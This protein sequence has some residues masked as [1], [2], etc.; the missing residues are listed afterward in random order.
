MCAVTQYGHRLAIDTPAATTSLSV[1]D[2]G[3]ASRDSRM[4]AQVPVSRGGEADST[5]KVVARSI[6]KSVASCAYTSATTP[7]AAPGGAGEVYRKVSVMATMLARRT[8]PGRRTREGS[9]G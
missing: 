9:R 8:V 5:T 1:R 3:P 2:V 4:T 6:P 7:V